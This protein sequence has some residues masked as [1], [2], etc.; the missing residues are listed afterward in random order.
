[1]NEMYQ[2]KHFSSEMAEFMAVFR[3]VI[4]RRNH[5]T[6][7]IV[8]FKLFFTSP[9]VGLMARKEKFD[10]KKKCLQRRHEYMHTRQGI[11]RNGS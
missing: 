5:L 9:P 11:D 10:Q 7:T 1:M 8:P 3:K 4:S 2:K 6:L